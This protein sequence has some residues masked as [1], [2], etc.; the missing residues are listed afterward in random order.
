[1]NKLIFLFLKKYSLIILQTLIINYFL[2]IY[3]YYIIK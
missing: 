2:F 1:M 3:S